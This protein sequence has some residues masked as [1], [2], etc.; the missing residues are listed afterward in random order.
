MQFERLSK[1][2]VYSNGVVIWQQRVPNHGTRDHT[3]KTL[4]FR[5]VFLSVSYSET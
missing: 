2:V 1:Q 3:Q 5:N 4:S